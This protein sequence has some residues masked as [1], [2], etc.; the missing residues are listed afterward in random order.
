MTIAPRDFARQHRANGTMD[1]PDLAL[2]AHRLAALERRPSR[3]DQLVVE[4]SV[5]VVV[6]PL[7]I[8][9]RHPGPGRCAMEQTAQIDALGLPVLDRPNHV[10]LVDPADHLLETSEAELRHQLANFF[11]DEEE[12]VDDMLGLAG[13]A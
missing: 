9:D 11:G 2:D 8:V 12:I 4:R 10:A 13:E 5:E 7:A 6:L 3:R 1:V